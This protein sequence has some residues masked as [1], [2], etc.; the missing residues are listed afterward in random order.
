[1]TYLI[2]VLILLFL[3]GTLTYYG[4]YAKAGIGEKP[5]MLNSSFIQFLYTILLIIALIYS[6]FLLFTDWKILLIG[7]IIHLIFRNKIEDFA[8]FPLAWLYSKLTEK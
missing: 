4:R 7:F 2:Q 6:G 1:M 8:N 3:L 5:L